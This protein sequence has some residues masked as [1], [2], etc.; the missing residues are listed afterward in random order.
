MNG[1]G[2][3]HVTRICRSRQGRHH[4]SGQGLLQRGSQCGLRRR[5]DPDDATLIAKKP[6]DY[7]PT[8]D[9]PGVAARVTLSSQETTA[10]AGN[11]RRQE[12]KGI[13]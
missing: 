13:L 7:D 3:M 5:P 12:D 11:D 6:D 8:A 10:N 2:S 1:Y 4:R 9:R